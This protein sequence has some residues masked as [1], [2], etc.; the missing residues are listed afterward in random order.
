[1]SFI[2]YA[3]NFEDI[4]LWRALKHINNGF[5]IDVGANDPTH[6]SVT[7]AF[8]DR[9]WHGINLEPVAEFYERLVVQRHRD[10]N[11]QIG[12]S[13]VVGNF[14]FFD[15]PGTGL[16]T[17]D[18]AVAQKHA[19][20]GWQV[21]TI[22]VP[23]LP[24]SNICEAH[25]NSEIHFLKI[26]VEGA[27]KKVL[28][29]IDLTKWRPWIIIVEATAPLTQHTAHQSWEYLLKDN[30]YEFVYFDGLNRFYIANEQKDL[31]A[32]F[33]L[34]PNDFDDFILWATQEAKNRAEEAEIRANKFK[35]LSQE[36]AE[37][38]I[39]VQKE[40]EVRLTETV[41]QRVE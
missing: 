17:L 8:Y 22:E 33:A 38:L 3:Q 16:A 11:L 37:R 15:I 14:P 25:V 2:S 1:M 19:D 12:V 30:A 20:A 40:L 28:V 34:P 7:R 36:A 23:L 5:Y 35:Q 32:A 24:L 13:D 6:F 21:N 29:G 27:E 31:K 4:M 26:D 10:I 18:S 9:G 41:I 39:L